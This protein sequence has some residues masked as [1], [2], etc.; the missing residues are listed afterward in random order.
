MLIRCKSILT[1]LYRSI[2]K[3]NFSVNMEIKINKEIRSYQE[4]IFFGLSL[5]QFLCS[6][7]AIGVALLIYFSM[8]DKMSSESLSWLCIM[9]AL[10][11]ASAGFITY[12]GL[13]FEA[14]LLTWL[15][16]DFVYPKQLVFKSEPIYKRIISLAHT[17]SSS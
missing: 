17:K 12:H 6:L 13:S 7:L 3:G 9:C 8:K 16:S 15:R 4:S 10:P 5:R 1:S 2:T 14:F 11:I